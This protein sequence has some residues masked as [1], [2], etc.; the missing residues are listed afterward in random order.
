MPTIMNIEKTFTYTHHRPVALGRLSCG[1]VCKVTDQNWSPKAHDEAYHYRTVGD[2]VECPCCARVERDLATLREAVE[3][4]E[5]HHTRVR[6]GSVWAYRR[7]ATSPSGFSSICSVENGPKVNAYLAT[8][9]GSGL[10]P[11]SPTERV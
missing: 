4:G 10:T 1:H 2:V 5:V 3:A 7:D 9:I 8:L 6:N 11:L